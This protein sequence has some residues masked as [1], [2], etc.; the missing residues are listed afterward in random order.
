MT[1]LREFLTLMGYMAICTGI[2]LLVN[3]LALGWI[4]GTFHWGERILALL[5]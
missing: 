3:L 5:R 4:I 2:I 1:R